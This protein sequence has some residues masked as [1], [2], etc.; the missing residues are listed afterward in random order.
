LT[1]AKLIKAKSIL[2]KNEVGKGEEL[3]FAYTQQQLDDLLHS[4]EEVKSSDYNAVK[5][6]VN[7]DVDTFMG[8][9]F[10]RLELLPL[11][12]STDVRTCFAYAKS[13]VVLSDAGRKAYMDI[14]PQRSHS[15]QIRSTTSLGATRLE[16]KKVVK[17]FCDESP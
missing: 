8:F 6:L 2:G 1:L 12:V 16:E 17:V 14:L 10:V 5:A 4:V 3:I 11:N 7:G 15:L 13:G 9:K